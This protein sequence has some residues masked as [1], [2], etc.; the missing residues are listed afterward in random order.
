MAERRDALKIIGAISATCAFPFSADELYGQHHHAQTAVPAPPAK[1]KHF[2]ADSLNLISRV[3]DLIIPETT[4]PSASAAG[5]PLYIDQVVFANEGHKRLFAEGLAWLRKADFLALD[6][7][8]QIA[9]LM[10]L[11][12]AVDKG[13]AKSMPERFFAIFKY[14]TADG[15]YTSQAGL[16]QE[17]GYKGNTVLAAFPEC[18][19]EH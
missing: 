9:M 16:M 5:V 18:T 17:L 1:P 19:H 6:E 13:K 7:D 2:D 4:T 14:L 11:C 3:A 8:K 12:E 10:P 15:Y